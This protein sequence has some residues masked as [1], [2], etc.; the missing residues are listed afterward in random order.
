MKIPSNQAEKAQ[1]VQYIVDCCMVSQAD[2]RALYQKRRQ[3]F[4]YGQEAEIKVRCN[5]LKSHL[6]LVSSFLFSPDGLL[7]NVTPPKNADEYAIKQFLA[8]QDD[9]NEDVHDS[10]IADVFADAVLWGLVFDSMVV[11]LGWNDITGQ[12]F[13]SLIEPVSFGV[14]REDDPQ[15][16][17]QQAMCHSYLLDYDDACTRLVRAGKRDQ[18]DILGKATGAQEDLGFPSPFMNLMVTEVTGSSLASQ[19]IMGN[20]NPNYSA[21]PTFKPRTEAPMVRFYESWIWD[22]DSK[23]FRIFTS[24]E[25]GILLSDSAETI[26]ILRIAGKFEKGQKFDSETNFYLP[27]KTPF[28]PVVPYSLYNY[29]WGDCHSED[30]IPLQDWSVKRLREIDE[31]LEAQVDPLRTAHGMTGLIDEKAGLDYG[32]FVA[33][34]MP[35]S[36]LEEHRPPMPEDAFREFNEITSLMME[37]SGL[38]EVVSGKSSGGARGGQQQKQ[39]QITGGGQIRRV[40]VGLENPL[41][42]M[43]DTGLRLKMKNDDSKIKLPDGTEFVAAQAPEDFQMRV[44][45][46]SH[47]PLF[48][49]ESRELAQMLFKAQA[50]DREWLIR[51]TN[52]TAKQNL[53]HSLAAREKQEAAQ[54]QQQAALEAAKHHKK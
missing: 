25:G 26:D 29:F 15:F 16:D 36:K 47:S 2:R 43:G 44:D 42:R 32:A 39:M 6:K 7:Y 53:L 12:I 33:D 40:A 46:H 38:T 22:D 14:W 23:D 20:A 17:N 30:I 10:G 11:K 34:D 24:L 51:M 41:L 9:W 3:Y 27:K 37:A 35:G 52:P 5:K 45:G 54:H 4:L 21:S 1:F 19:T 50:I 8:L 28:T 48:T 31:I 18:I 13:A 49:M